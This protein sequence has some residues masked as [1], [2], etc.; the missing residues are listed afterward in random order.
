VQ[1]TAITVLQRMEQLLSIQNQIVGVDD[2]NN[3]NELQSNLC[4]VIIVR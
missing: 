1:K 2:R 4:G 3:W